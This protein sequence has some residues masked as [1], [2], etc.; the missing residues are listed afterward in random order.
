MGIN[1]TNGF[2]LLLIGCGVLILLDKIGFGLGGLLSIIF[3][4]VLIVLGYVGIKHGRGFIGWTLMIF[5]LIILFGK[6]TGII[7]WLIA[8]GLIAYGVH[9][10][11]KRNSVY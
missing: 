8:I 3:P 6:L 2:A 1:K 9:M 7:G 11:K 10:L 5:G 4:I